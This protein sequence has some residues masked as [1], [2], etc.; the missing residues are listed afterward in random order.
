MSQTPAVESLQSNLIN[1]S[2]SSSII[3]GLIAFVLL[4]GMTIYQTMHVHDEIMDEIS[5][6]LLISDLSASSGQQMDELSDEFDVEYQLKLG[7]QL[8][9]QSPKFS[10]NFE[11]LKQHYFVREGY[12][13]IWLD[14]T[15]MRMYVFDQGDQ[16]VRM[17][18]PF[19][20]RF[21]D[22]LQSILGYGLILI[23]LWLIQWGILKFS[24]KK[25]FRSIHTLSKEISA[26]SADDL[27]PI[28]QQQ[29]ELEELQPMVMQLNQLLT[30]LQY[31]LQAEQ[32]FTA[33]ASHE[34]RS[35]LSAIQMRLQLLKRKYGE[36]MPTLVQDIQQMSTDVARGTQVLEN[37][38][39][40]ARLD[41]SHNSEL[42]HSQFDM[43]DTIQAVSQSLSLMASE[44]DIAMHLQLQSGLIDANRDL[45]F[46]CV[47]N[48]V[49]NALR[50][51]EHGGQVKI[52][53][54]EQGQ[55]VVLV[56]E[57]SGQKVSEE[58]L[59]RL[60]ERFYR[61]LGTKTT[62]SG[63][64]LSICKKIIELHHGDMQ[65][66]ASDLEGL[67]VQVNLAKA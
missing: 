43:Q 62:G 51:A 4:M 65:F 8:L 31:S 41:P 40:L 5:D 22:V 10:P 16:H 14:G 17:Y 27:T 35:P 54:S 63:L 3:A 20:E 64:G 37:L 67:K 36:S 53:L 38:L 7:P 21:K 49:D 34:L 59:Q 13:Y 50:Y 60:G 30:R 25:Q 19:H 1:T 28:R 9:T 11:A 29:P 44:K 6:M 33:D 15:L 2:V 32:R 58:V 48:L 56:V 12:S 24:I 18:Q 26:K 66:S 39:L 45:I 61:Q 42:P 57:N 52:E 55:Q 46:T 23:L 47:R